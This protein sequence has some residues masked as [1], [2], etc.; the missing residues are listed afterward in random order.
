MRL[1]KEPV[2]P[3]VTVA[4]LFAHHL[5]SYQEWRPF[6]LGWLDRDS[7]HALASSG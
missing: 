7:Q 5:K 2:K 6:L 3:R 1:M 4:Q